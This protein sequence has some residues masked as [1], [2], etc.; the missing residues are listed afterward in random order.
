MKNIEQF[1]LFLCHW[2]FWK[3][4]M[5]FLQQ[6]VV[7]ILIMVLKSFNP[8]RYSATDRHLFA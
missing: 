1:G 7:S 3:K 6:N 5:S 4:C 8:K 2:C